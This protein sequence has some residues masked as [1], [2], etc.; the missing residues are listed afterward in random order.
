MEHK[1]PCACEKNQKDLVT[2]SNDDHTSKEQSKHKHSEVQRS[3]AI[4]GQGK[5]QGNRRRVEGGTDGR[6]RQLPEEWR[7]LS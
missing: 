7:Y 2:S 3:L 4:R 5:G 1:P 6:R